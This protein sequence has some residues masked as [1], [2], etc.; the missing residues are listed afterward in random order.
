VARHEIVAL[1]SAG[2][3]EALRSGR[4]ERVAPTRGLAVFADPVFSVDDERLAAAGGTLADDPTRRAAP[5]DR[6]GSLLSRAA[7]D[8]G[9]AGGVSRLPFTRREA[10]ALQALAPERTR[11][12][13]DFDASRE[14]VLDPQLATYRYVHF[15]T[16]GL[17][18][19]RNPELSG[20]V[21]SLVDRG[22][23]PQP[24]YL[25]SAEIFNL[26]LSADLAVLSGCRT[27]L[28]REVRGEGLVGLTRGFLYA[29]ADR[30]V[31]SLWKVDD[32]ATA[33]LM[34]GFYR[35]LL[36]G[37]GLRPA[38]ALRA[39]QLELAR[40]PRFAH[41]YFWAAFQLVGEWR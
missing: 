20:L 41:P 36:G 38:A 26:R 14:A 28:G 13:L 1:P 33:A 17:I 7:E 5:A 6:A 8:L 25:T 9:G 24:G 11:L 21:L 29:G 31:A 39:A 4:G 19:D 23:R 35:Q 2:V 15:A 40:E 34:S 18:D 10:L 30:V 27:G 37:A 22:G 32:A 3:L 16:H 12:A